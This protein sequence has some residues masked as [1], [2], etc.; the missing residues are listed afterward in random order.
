MLE[1]GWFG[2]MSSVVTGSCKRAAIERGLE[3]GSKGIAIVGTITR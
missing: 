2:A 3:Q 1:P